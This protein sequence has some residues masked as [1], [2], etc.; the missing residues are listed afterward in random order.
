[1]SAPKRYAEVR[2]FVIV[3][4][5]ITDDELAEALK[6]AP[7]QPSVAELVADEIASNLE[8]LSYVDSTIVSQL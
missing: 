1:M 2:L 7:R 6:R 8:S 4:V 5:N 3:T